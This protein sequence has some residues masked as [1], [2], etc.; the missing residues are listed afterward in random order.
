MENNMTESCPAVVTFGAGSF[1]DAEAAFRHARGVLVTVVG[2]M[3]GTTDSPTYEEVSSG[4]TGHSEVVMVAYDP[5][6]VSFRDLLAVFFSYHNPCERSQG[7]YK[8]ARY[9]PVIFCHDK[10]DKEQ[11]EDYIRELHRSGHCPGGIVTRISPAM[12]FYPA[13]E[14]PQQYYE[15]VAGCYPVLHTGDLGED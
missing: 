14:Y 5:G 9:E 10:K 1:W 7:D 15:K 3:G 11:A 2:F 13:E 6:Q 12:T 4:E 8:G